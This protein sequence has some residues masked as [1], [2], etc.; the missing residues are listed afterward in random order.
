M[1][2]SKNNGLIVALIAITFFSFNSNSISS[3]SGGFTVTETKSETLTPQGVKETKV[4]KDYNFSFLG[5][6][7]SD[8]VVIKESLTKKK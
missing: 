5:N 7:S 6:S 1:K 4:S 8:V 3:Y 2:I